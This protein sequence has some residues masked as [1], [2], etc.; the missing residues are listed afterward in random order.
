MPIRIITAIFTEKC[1]GKLEYFRAYQAR[2]SLCRFTPAFDTNT[3][4]EHREFSRAQL[5]ILADKANLHLLIH[6]KG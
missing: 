1:P 2:G 5:S 6:G 3:M 4:T